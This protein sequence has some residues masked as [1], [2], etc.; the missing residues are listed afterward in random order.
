MVFNKDKNKNK[1]THNKLNLRDTST[2]PVN[3]YGDNNINRGVVESKPEFNDR[4]EE[5]DSDDGP[6]ELETAYTSPDNRRKLANE[7]R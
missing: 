6:P 1:A 5:P 3:L 7:R 2:D 4:E